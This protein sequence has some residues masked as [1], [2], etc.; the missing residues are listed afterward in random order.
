MGWDAIVWDI[1]GVGWAWPWPWPW[2]VGG[3]DDGWV[4]IDKDGKVCMG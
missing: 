3:M 4:V 1:D 2:V